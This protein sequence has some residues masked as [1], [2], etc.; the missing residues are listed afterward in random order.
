MA[1]LLRRSPA[2]LTAR[3]YPSYI[4]MCDICCPVKIIAATSTTQLVRLRAVR[5]VLNCVSL[6]ANDM[7]T[8]QTPTGEGE[9]CRV[10]PPEESC[11]AISDIYIYRV[12]GVYSG[13]L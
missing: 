5:E 4:Y 1:M 13:T 12:K 11:V 7:S 9:S 6:R 10:L 2:K 8:Q 3:T